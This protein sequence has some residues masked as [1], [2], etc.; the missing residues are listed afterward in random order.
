MVAAQ[1]AAKSAATA[2]QDEISDSF[3][4]GGI[5]SSELQDVVKQAQLFGDAAGAKLLTGVGQGGANQIADDIGKS[6]GLAGD[7]ARAAGKEIV[8]LIGNLNHPVLGGAG[9]FQALEDRLAQLSK[10]AGKSSDKVFAMIGNLSELFD[11]GRI[12]SRSI[13]GLK[14]SLDSLGKGEGLGATSSELSEIDEKLKSLAQELA[15]SEAGLEGNATEAMRLQA[16]FQFGVSTFAEMPEEA[17]RM[18]NRLIEIGEIE[19]ENTKKRIEAKK[20]E[21]EA[22]IKEERRKSEILKQFGVVSGANDE[23]NR[24]ELEKL[25]SKFEQE[26]IIVAEHHA[27]MLEQKALSDEQ[28][29]ALEQQTAS[30]ITAINQRESDARLAIQKKHEDVVLQ[31]KMAA[32][33]NAAALLSQFAGQSKVAAIAAIALNK[34][35]ALAQNTQNTLVA[36]TRALAELGPIAGP[37]AAATIGSYG[38]ANA[39]LIAATGLAQAANAARGSAPAGLAGLSGGQ[40][41]S[42]GGGVGPQQASR[43]VSIS[44]TGD[45]F[46]SGG[47]RGLIDEINEAVGDGVNV[48]ASGG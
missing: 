13:E 12:A 41:S 5:L 48:F 24:T 26:R 34:G 6:F 10:G 18:V 43:N 44:L 29:I 47:I 11:K 20:L 31:L 37:P 7:D 9:A 8:E 36:Q 17:Q 2:I 19:K 45:N 3:D 46:G 40:G 14:S 38:A 28:L 33:S 4:L 25:R 32:V 23:A 16:A 15:L 42:S 35:L 27:L 30:Q 21:T 1:K 22:A 39:A